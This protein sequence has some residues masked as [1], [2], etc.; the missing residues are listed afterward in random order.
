MRR[1][2]I[3]AACRRISKLLIA[4]LEFYACQRTLTEIP[5]VYIHHQRA[6][7]NAAV[8]LKHAHTVDNH[9]A[10]LRSSGNY[11]TAR[12]HAE[13]IGC[14]CF[15]LR[16][17]N[18]RVIRCAQQMMSGKAAVLRPVN[19][20]LRM[21]D[22]HA[23]SK[24]FRHN[25]YAPAC[26]HSVG[27]TRTVTAGQYH[28][29]CR[30][31]FAAV[32]DYALDRIIFDIQINNMRIVAHAATQ[33][34]NAAA[35]SLYHRT[36]L[37]RA[38]VRLVLVQNIFRRTC[39]YKQLQDFSHHRII[40]ACSQL[41]VREGACTALAELYV[42]RGVK[43]S[44][45]PKALYILHALRHRLAALQKQRL[46][47]MLR[48]L[49]CCQKSRRTGTDNH[50]RC[51]QRQ[52][53]KLQRRLLLLLI[54][55]NITVRQQA[56]RLSAACFNLCQHMIVKA[57]IIFLARI[58]CLAYYPHTAQSIAR[59]TA[60]AAHRLLQRLLLSQADTH[61]INFQLHL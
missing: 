26:Q 50:R 39:S 2:I 9:A 51:A 42:G 48:Q 31:P 11:L 59:Y 21:L 45:L 22:A 36:Q 44:R 60:F 34:R 46:I 5:A 10:G 1:R 52:C 13:R 49:Q 35:E 6:V 3:A 32:N 7:G 27:I 29:S 47:A 37:I 57:D 33:L 43:F 18:K 14:A 61:I 8:T 54:L 12:A 15:I 16:V 28:G 56:L 19:Q 4:A 58:H 55:C 23:D 17:V 53:A 41:A 25:A 30:Q 40:D 38:Y 20:L 24:W